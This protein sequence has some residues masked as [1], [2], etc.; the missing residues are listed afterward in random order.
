M[1]SQ[2]K[3]LDQ[4]KELSNTLSPEPPFIWPEPRVLEGISCYEPEIPLKTLALVSNSIIGI[5]SSLTCRGIDTLQEWVEANEGL[6]VRLL[7]AVYPTG[8]TTREDLARV[9]EL[10]GRHSNRFEARITVCSK[11]TD[12]PTNGLCFHRKHDEI[13]HMA[14][15]SSENLGFDS[16][17]DFKINFVFRADATLTELF[18][19]YFTWMWARSRP[20]EAEGITLIPHLVIPEGT[21]EAAQMW[22]QYLVVCSQIADQ[23][24][25]DAPAAVVDPSSGTVQI[26]SEDGKT[27]KSPAQEIGIPALDP[28]AEKI[29]RIYEKG[30]LVSIDKLSRIPPLDAPL[31]PSAFGDSSE[32]H[33]GNVVRKVS[34]RV[35]IIDDKTLKEIDKRRQGIRALLAKFTFGLADNMRWMPSTAR[36][37]FEVEL[38]RLNE[39]GQG[40]ITKLLRGNVSAFIE[41]K[42]ERLTADIS[43]MY[44]ELGRPGQVTPDIIERVVDSLKARLDKAESANFMPA[45]SYSNVSFAAMENSFASPWGQ[46]FSLLKDI[47]IFPRKAMIDSFFLRGLKIPEDSLIE[48]MNVADDALLRN[49]QVRGIK[50]H[51]KAELDLLTRIERAQM[52]PRSRCNLVCDI[53]AGDSIE[54]IEETLKKSES[55][56]P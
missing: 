40:L 34:M 28:L 4:S 14:I 42:R 1:L 51:C 50:D 26:K 49:N 41:S 30:S 47:A 27:L 56:L 21:E 25:K 31:D 18:S 38:N 8:P 37:L 36:D 52:E 48:A 54:K 7:I 3:K 43:A 46:A 6:Q 55:A 11:L 33:K 22:Q 13:C 35:S 45:L 32:I 24:N 39:E 19:R 53:L 2:E 10:A 44:A 16:S 29:A 9:K 20:I 12:R 15:G 5:V 17:S 23:T